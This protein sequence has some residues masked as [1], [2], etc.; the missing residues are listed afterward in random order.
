MRQLILA[1]RGPHHLLKFVAEVALV[2]EVGVVGKDL[3]DRFGILSLPGIITPADQL[4]YLGLAL[5]GPSEVVN[6]LTGNIGLLR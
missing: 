4:H 1:R 6:K 5:Y 2:R 3:F